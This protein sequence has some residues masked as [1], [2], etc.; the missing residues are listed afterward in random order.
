MDNLIVLLDNYATAPNLT[1]DFDNPST[2]STTCCKRNA[3]SN[4]KLSNFLLVLSDFFLVYILMFL[5]NFKMLYDIVVYSHGNCS[6]GIAVVAFLPCFI[7]ICIVTL[8]IYI[9]SNVLI[10][11]YMAKAKLITKNISEDFILV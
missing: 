9:H 5:I 8:L 4:W 1:Y 10:I 7:Y 3:T 11:F 2:H 6:N